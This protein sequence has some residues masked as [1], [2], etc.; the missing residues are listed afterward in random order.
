MR[1]FILSF[2]LW[3][4]L[5]RRI[6][7]IYILKRDILFCLWFFF[8]SLVAPNMFLSF[9]FYFRGVW[10]FA[11]PLF[12]LEVKSMSPSFSCTFFFKRGKVYV[13][14]LFSCI[15][16]SCFMRGNVYVPTD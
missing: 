6:D 3:N 16:F 10:S 15:L 8:S 5:T 11:H 2:L 14:P 12:S 4:W 1:S 7:K 9:R 13:F